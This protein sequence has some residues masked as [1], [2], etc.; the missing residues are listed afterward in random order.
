M[1]T[2]CEV[3]SLE[4]R[5]NF[6]MQIQK[7]SKAFVFLTCGADFSHTLN[8]HLPNSAGPHEGH[9]ALLG[10]VGYYKLILQPIVGGKKNCSVFFEL[11]CSTVTPGGPESYKDRTEP[12]RCWRGSPPNSSFSSAVA[13]QAFIG[14]VGE[15]LKPP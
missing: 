5:K 4:Y 3:T 15:A 9:L 7:I 12:V 8:L 11:C 2:L 6:T 10:L 14:P 13:Q 1:L